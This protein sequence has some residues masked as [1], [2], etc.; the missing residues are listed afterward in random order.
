[1]IT[2]RMFRLKMLRLKNGCRDSTKEQLDEV[3]SKYPLN[4]HVDALLSFRPAF[5][6]PL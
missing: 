3:E 5:L 6:E 1:M 4:E 2:T